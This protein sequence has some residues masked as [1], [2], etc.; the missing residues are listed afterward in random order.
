MG[1]VAAVGGFLR[2]ESHFEI[3]FLM[4][5]EPLKE[6]TICLSTGSIPTKPRVSSTVPLLIGSDTAMAA[7]SGRETYMNEATTVALCES[8][9]EH[10]FNL[11]VTG[12]PAAFSLLQPAAADHWAYSLKLFSC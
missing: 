7:L 10:W 6:T 11:Q 8:N 5:V 3:Q 12:S 2:G 4:E 9:M 1:L